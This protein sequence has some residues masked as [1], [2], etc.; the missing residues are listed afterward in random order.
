[1]LRA[2]YEGIVFSHRMHIEK[3]L[4]LSDKP[5][6]IRIA[7]GVTKAPMW[8]QMFADALQMP[9]EVSDNTELGTMGAAMCA[10][11]ATGTHSTLLAASKEFSKISYTCEPNTKN[12][13]VYDKKYKLYKKVISKLETLWMEWNK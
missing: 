4:Q 9:I 8:V 12:Q 6:C 7:G 13:S 2:V 3:L 10:S 1:M 5:K 11:V